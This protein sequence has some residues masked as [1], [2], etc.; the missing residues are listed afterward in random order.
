MKEALEI[1][2]VVLGYGQYLRTFGEMT[3]VKDN[4]LKLKND[5][6]ERGMMP[7]FVGYAD[8]SKEL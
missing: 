1:E 7:M 2:D 5:L 8:M 4:G 6:Q 3:V